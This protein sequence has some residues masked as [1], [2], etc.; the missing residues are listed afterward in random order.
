MALTNTTTLATALP[1]LISQRA[2]PYY[3]KKRLFSG[4]IGPENIYKLSKGESTLSVNQLGTLTMG[5]RTEATAQTEA[6]FTTTEREFTPITHGVNVAISTEAL[7]R[8]G[9][10]VVDWIGEAAATAWAYQEET[11]AT[12]SFAALYIEADDAS[13]DHRIGVD[14][15]AVDAAICRQGAQLLMTSGAGRPY[16]WVIDPL[17][18]EELM[19]DSEAKQY[20]MNTKGNAAATYGVSDERYLGQIYGVHVWVSDEMIQTSG[21]WSI[22]FG[23]DAFGK[24]WR[25]LQSPNNTTPGELLTDVTWEAD[26]LAWRLTFAVCQQMLGQGWATQ[27]SRFIVSIVS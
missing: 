25:E 17:Q 5:L 14:G 22:M 7:D 8:A 4:L 21:P 23:K 1:T 15:T 26:L 24:A 11:V 20:L 27:T 3:H 2:I 10:N 6:A 9:A 18:F 16:H 12:Y 19:R 13:P